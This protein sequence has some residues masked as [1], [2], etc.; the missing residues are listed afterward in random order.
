VLLYGNAAG[1][2]TTIGVTQ[3]SPTARPPSGDSGTTVIVEGSFRLASRSCAQV[4]EAMPNNTARRSILFPQS[5]FFVESLIVFRNLK[6]KTK[7][8]DQIRFRNL[9]IIH[10]KT[11]YCFK[12]L[13]RKNNFLPV[14]TAQK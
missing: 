11:Y 1:I 5:H 3:S 7:L 6:V 8:L 13:H 4:I 14:L 10:P 12:R 9:L 2:L